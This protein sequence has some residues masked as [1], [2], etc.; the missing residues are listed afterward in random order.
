MKDREGTTTPRSGGMVMTLSDL[1]TLTVRLD[2]KEW[3]GETLYSVVIKR[4]GKIIGIVGGLFWE[5]AE[6][7]AAK[8]QADVLYQSL[9]VTAEIVAEPKG[10]Q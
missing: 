5:H 7:T 2:P 9:K 1:E 10:E 6:N 3:T 4:E 8:V